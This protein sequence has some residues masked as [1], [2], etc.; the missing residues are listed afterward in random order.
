[1][2]TIIAAL[3]GFIGIIA[4]AMI[5]AFKNEIRRF[6]LAPGYKAESIECQIEF[7]MTRGGSDPDMIKDI[8]RLKQVAFLGISHENLSTYL[9]MLLEKLDSGNEISEIR[10]Y[11]ASPR[12]GEL[13][14]E[15]QFM[16]HVKKTRQAI[17]ELLTNPGLAWAE[18]KQKVIEFSFWHARHHATYGGCIMEGKKECVIYTASYLPTAQPDT[19][20]SLTFRLKSIEGKEDCSKNLVN[21]YLN[22]YKYIKMQAVS[23]GRFIPSL[24]DLSAKEW[25]EFTSNCTAYQESMEYLCRIAKFIKNEKVLDMACGDGTTSLILSSWVGRLTILDSSPRMIQQAKKTLEG[26]ATFALLSIPCINTE[27]IDLEDKYDV[28]ISHLSLPA[29]AETKDSLKEL[30]IWCRNHIH[31]GGKIIFA[32]HNT[33]VRIRSSTYRIEADTL[34]Q[35]FREQA[36]ELHELNIYRE[37][38]TSQFSKKDINDAF[39]KAGF[40]KVC[41]KEKSFQMKMI[42]RI[43]MWSA[44]AV[45]DTLFDVRRLTSKRKKSLMADVQDKII[46]KNTPT[47]T[48]I[49]WIFEAIPVFKES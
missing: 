30:A 25:A 39:S 11:Y 22:A 48:V 38:C 35:E 14:E 7:Y 18:Y 10:I 12:D 6:L 5:H 42:D 26:K 41:E 17:A 28:I 13:W 46:R 33:S 31:E 47:M 45:L 37:K 3:I 24:W 34:R 20:K 44:P 4:G 32:A 43:R 40:K 27:E 36:K 15:E 21:S 9:F 49:Y 1:M 19:K 29:I 8:L 16:K 23:L 2:Y